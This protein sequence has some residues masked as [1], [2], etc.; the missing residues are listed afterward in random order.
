[1]NISSK[2]IIYIFSIVTASFIL[3]SLKWI[4]S[5]HFFPDEEIT[6]RVINES[7]DDS[8]TYFHYI[9]SLS[10]FDFKSLYSQI[11]KTDDYL[12][13]PYGSVIFHTILYKT[14]GINSFIFLEFVS[15][16]VFITI[17]ILIFKLL[18]FTNLSS[19]LF[20]IILYTSPNLIEHYNFINIQ[21][22][23]TFTSNFY[24]LRFPRPFVANLLFFFFIYVLLDC[25]IKKNIFEFKNLIILSLIFSLSFS[26]FFFFFLNEVTTFI[27][28]LIF[29]FK[30]NILKT[31]YKNFKNIIISLILFIILVLPFVFLILNAS[32]DYMQRMGLIPV[33]YQDK[34]Y[35][36]KY[37]FSKIFRLKLI[38]IYIFLFINFIFLKKFSPNDLKYVNIFY[39]LFFSSLISP[40]IFI[41]FS[42][43]IAFLY[44][45]NNTVVICL[46]LLIIILFLINIRI[47]FKR[48]N[49]IFY[50][51]FSSI[52]FIL[53][54]LISYNSLLFKK[55]LLDSI[56]PSRQD[57]N[58]IVN[59]LNKDNNFELKKINFQTFDTKLMTWLIFNNN[60]NL[61][62]IDGTF[63][64]R[65]NF[66][67]ENDL[68]KTFKFL[69]LSENDFQK[70]IEN[71]KLG[72]RYIN[73]DLRTFFWQRYSANSL[74]KFNNSD[75][76][77]PEVL[78]FLNNSSPY[79]SHQFA[80]P[81]FE[82]KRLLEKFNNFNLKKDTQD[83]FIVVE[84]NH[85]I[86][87]K[88]IIDDSLYCEKYV[89]SIFN[90]YV[91]ITY[92]N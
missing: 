29:Y 3:F 9:K 63:T 50:K 12:P 69:K 8:H 79:Y 14:F 61:D 84:K 60:Q 72:Y 10:I 87:S 83:K 46:V 40:I 16:L 32:D 21:E 42:N 65:K 6:L 23:N 82:V 68:I 41:I 51:K 39:L 11:L 73:H 26:S 54:L 30:K 19:L 20:A 36:F 45:F 75:D 90:F 28:Y 5:F 59:F 17:F 77:D 55:Y 43:K 33:N 27:L 91:P 71:K 67:I 86:L 88:S 49:S 57:R 53:L 78:K 7:L 89:G 25:H 66:E 58:Y 92:C 35:L 22:L 48:F 85:L 15:I 70:F 64:L 37:Y 18:R 1:M 62:L 74:Y 2:N 76:F 56:E 13:I 4:L 81:N 34:I 38:T 80:L 31:L 47:L 44:H 52:I 24:N